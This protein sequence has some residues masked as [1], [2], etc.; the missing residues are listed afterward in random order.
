MANALQDAHVLVIGGPVSSARS[1]W[2][3]CCR[4]P[5]RQVTVYD[6]FTRGTRENLAGALRDP[7][8][9][10]FPLAETSAHTD[11]L[12]RAFEGVDYV[13]HTAALWLLHCPS[14]RRA[15]ST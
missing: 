7:R 14:S 3:S 10:I 5:V 9:R 8:C 13:I 6:N 15:P 12:D 2:T 4:K 1:L 11:I